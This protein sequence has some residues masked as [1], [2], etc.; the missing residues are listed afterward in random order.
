MAKY[1]QIADALRAGIRTG[2]LLPG[3]RLPAEDKLAARYRTS[4]PTLQRAL[5]EL[6]AEGLIDKRHGVGT[7]V[8]TPR[9][10]I[11]RNNDRHQWEKDRA[12]R[13]RAERLR[14]GST[15][16][17]TG[18]EVTDLAFHAEYRDAQADEDLAS[19]FGVPVD[20]R[21]L[22]RIYRTNCRTED[23][24]FAL[25]H[26]YLVH[27][28][29]AANPDLLDAANEPWP[30]GTQNQLYTIG[31]ELDRVEERITARPPT[32]E[33]AEELGLKKGVSV[34]L[35]RKICT[36]IGGRVVEVSD[37][38]LAADRTELVYTTPLERW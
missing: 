13:S 22:E 6:V 7:F 27:D 38:T 9:R 1:E 12:R 23:A 20:T 21:L 32:V 8:R 31:I 10:R 28:V 37:V 34:I 2:R 33:E 14:T 35:L 36:D 16:H 11:E 17:D 26:S 3:E 19:V 29:V 25:V 4:V 5:S 15:E 24:P 18:L 30:G